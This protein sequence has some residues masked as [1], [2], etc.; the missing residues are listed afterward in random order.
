MFDGSGDPFM[1]SNRMGPKVVLI[2]AGSLFF[3]AKT[4]W[5]MATKEALCSGILVLVELDEQKLKWM[6]QIAD[7]VVASRGIPLKVLATSDPRKALK[8]ADFV[9][10]AMAQNS[11][12]L[13]D[14]DSRISTRHGM[15]MCSADTIG[16]GGIMRTLREVPIQ[17]AVLRD[18]ERLCPEAWVMN[19]INPT[20]AMGIAMM[21]HFPKIKSM[22]LCDCVQNP[23][24]DDNLIVRAGLT[25]SVAEVTKA[26]RRRVKIISGGVNH[27]TWLICMTCDGKDQTAR[28]KASLKQAAVMEHGRE[29]VEKD[30]GS[31]T[32]RI[33][34]QL[35]D[36]VGYAPMCT[37]HT[38]EYLPYFQGHGVHKK[39]VLTIRRWRAD[40]RRQWMRQYWK[41]AASYAAG[42][43]PIEQFLRTTTA[44]YASDIIES[45]WAGRPRR[46]YL[47]T[48][49]NG[50]ISNLT[51]DAYVEIPCRPDMS[52]LHPLPFGPLPRPILGYVQR[53]LDEHELAVEAA[54]TC[55]RRVLRRAFLAS[56]VAVSIPDVDACMNE[57]LAK[58]QAYLPARW[59]IKG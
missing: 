30:H 49:N 40:L 56:M 15:I 18:I 14:L 41:E 36:A 35:A 37:G 11:V 16:P 29:S 6:K 54:I 45:M 19:W 7:R 55:D 10:L 1:T 59:R 34:W 48:P 5:S 3:G 23:A 27:F 32:A 53:V 50:A 26:L 17:Q 33:A 51:D 28:I 58:E 39:G 43:T 25:A 8:G 52:G 22:A 47:N 44:D 42:R 12:A 46:C 20:S 9:I 2:G 57:M 31:L 4:I 13:R 38:Q 21:R 24:F